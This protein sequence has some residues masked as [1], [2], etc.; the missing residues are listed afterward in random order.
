MIGTT[1]QSV[2]IVDFV[3]LIVLQYTGVTLLRRLQQRHTAFWSERSFPTYQWEIFLRGSGGWR[4]HRFIWSGE[5]AT[6]DDA[7]VVVYAWVMRLATLVILAATSAILVDA[8]TK[9][10]LHAPHLS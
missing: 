2:L 6:L 10:Q 7:T 5:P 3:A 8:F 4:M 1:Y 9:W